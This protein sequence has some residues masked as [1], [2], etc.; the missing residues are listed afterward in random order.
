MRT[1]LFSFTIS[2]CFVHVV[3]SQETR[4]SLDTLKTIEPIITQSIPNYLAPLLITGNQPYNLNWKNP[5]SSTIQFQFDNDTTQKTIFSLSKPFVLYTG[6]VGLSLYS[7][8]D[9]SKD[10]P[11]N[12]HVLHQ[13]VLSE[14]KGKYRT[15]ID[16]YTQYAPLVITAGL[17]LAGVK[18]KNDLLN[19]SILAAK[20]FVLSSGISFAFKYAIPTTRPSG[21]DIESFPSGH[22]TV[23]FT[24]ATIMHMEFKDT[25]PW[26]SVLGYTFATATGA[27]RIINNKHWLPDVLAGAVIG[28]ASTQLV[29]ATHKYRWGKKPQN[30]VIAPTFSSKHYGATLAYTF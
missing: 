29:Y 28:M 1:L 26:Y 2:L 6:L 21:N 20:S 30:L 9:L 11:I 14:L 4:T 27:M 7:M 19:S 12:K 24:T 23:A 22:T 3:K 16:D 10:S 13:N 15:N 8:S 18:S 5:N 25:S 17:K